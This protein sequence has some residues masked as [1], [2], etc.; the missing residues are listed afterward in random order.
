M[1]STMCGF[2]CPHDAMAANPCR[3]VPRI[4]VKPR[5]VPMAPS[6]AEVLQ[7]RALLTY[8]ELAVAHDLPDPVGLLCATGMRIGEVCALSWDQVDLSAGT[9]EVTGTVLQTGII[10][11]R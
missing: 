5:S 4:P 1:L 10:A 7:L 6:G 11:T 9:L 2:A 8:N 3:E